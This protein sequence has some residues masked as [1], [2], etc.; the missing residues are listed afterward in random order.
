MAETMHE[1][2]ENF[3][4]R[5]CRSV[6]SYHA[7]GTISHQSGKQ[8]G[9]GQDQAY[10]KYSFYGFYHR[11]YIFGGFEVCIYESPDGV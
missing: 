4:F 10:S 3:R 7:V 5:Q 2:P 1:V 11:E 8:S 6:H 9:F